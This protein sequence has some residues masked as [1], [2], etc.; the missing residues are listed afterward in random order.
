MRPDELEP[1]IAAIRDGGWGDRT[2][3]LGFYSRSAAMTVLVAKESR[4]IV[5]TTVVSSSAG[6]GWIGLVFVAPSMRGRG[7]GSTLTRAGLA[8]LRESRTVLLAASE[9]GRPIYERLG[10]EVEGRYAIMRGPT[11]DAFH[12]SAPAIRADDLDRIL[13][14]DRDATGED[15]AHLLEALPRGWVAERG[16]ALRP[17]WGYGPVIAEDVSSGEALIDAVRANA[18]GSELTLRVPSANAAAMQYLVSRGF[19]EVGALPRM[20]LGDPVAWRPEMIWAIT[21]FALG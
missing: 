2:A 3:E 15:R 4:T 8:A 10:F 19:V 13:R 17:P 16:F 14:L 18:A 7:L 20:R 9:M 12:H 21:N 1:A 6:V 5:G 11:A